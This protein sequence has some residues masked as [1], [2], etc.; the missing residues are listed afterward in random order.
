[1]GKKLGLQYAIQMTLAIAAVLPHKDNHK[2]YKKSVQS[3]FDDQLR[4]H[5]WFNRAQRRQRVAELGRRLKEEEKIQS[6][7]DAKELT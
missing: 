2:L 3:I 7:P 5:T 4:L 1:M 6:T